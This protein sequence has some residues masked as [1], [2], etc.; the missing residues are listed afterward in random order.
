MEYE[1]LDGVQ[2]A[3][4]SEKGAEIHQDMEEDS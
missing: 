3:T 4:S 1:L 2:T